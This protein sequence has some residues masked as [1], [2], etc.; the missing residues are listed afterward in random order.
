[1]KE[2]KETVPTSLF[3]V[4][5]KNKYLTMVQAEEIVRI[6]DEGLHDIEYVA[7]W[8][9]VGIRIYRGN[10]E[11]KY[12]ITLKSILGEI[13]SYCN[14]IFIIDDNDKDRYIYAGPVIKIRIKPKE[15]E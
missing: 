4:S 6:C 13:E 12:R 15:S 1:M 7:I 2:V 8:G 14:S 11:G 5:D 10:K 3:I 9:D